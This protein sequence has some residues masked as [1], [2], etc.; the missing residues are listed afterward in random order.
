MNTLSNIFKVSSYIT[1]V[2]WLILI[3]T[4][5]W[6]FGLNTV[7]FI[8]VSLLCFIY[9]YLIFFAKKLDEGKPVRGSFWSLKGV[10]NLFKS[11][12][13][14]LAGWVHYLAFDLMMGLY[15]VTDAA[16]FDISHW[17]LIPCLIMTLMFGPAGL[18]IYFALKMAMTGEL[19]LSFQF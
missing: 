16:R 18:L 14:V 15:I 5:N 19:D 10:I 9:S 7:V 8:V 2:G 4:P 11:P 3:V 6:S 1:L 17:L 13:A 12:R